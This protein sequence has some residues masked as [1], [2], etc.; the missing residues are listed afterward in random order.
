M[1]TI[2]NL[3]RIE[4]QFILLPHFN[5]YGLP[6][7]RLI[8]KKWKNVIDDIF[9]NIFK[10]KMPALH[11][12]LLFDKTMYNYYTSHEN[13]SDTTWVKFA[14]ID[15]QLEL[16][17]SKRL[18]INDVKKC[19]KYA[20]QYNSIN[21]INFFF[22][23]L[24]GVE[25]Y[26]NNKNDIV[27]NLIKG[28]A[29]YYDEDCMSMIIHLWNS[30]GRELSELNL[31]DTIIYLI[32]HNDMDK[33]RTMYLG[34]KERDFEHVKLIIKHGSANLINA[35]LKSFSCRDDVGFCIMK[36]GNYHTNPS[37]QYYRRIALEIYDRN[38]INLLVAT[39]QFFS[40]IWQSIM[41]DDKAIAISL[42][43]RLKTEPLINDNMAKNYRNLN[44]N[45]DD[46]LQI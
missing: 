3:S 12:V 44:K 5:K 9:D 31:T 28:S 8:S 17:K 37:Y 25:Y 41:W 21:I 4:L 24:F 36:Y 33:L 14:A 10:C 23:T 7:L 30:S 26:G 40:L 35:F 34:Y 22:G 43:Q 46:I 15:D 45:I 32:K 20:G 27:L 39:Y 42:F 19:A 16:F 38:D 11:K 13:I 29:K 6:L 1:F 18:T 2:D